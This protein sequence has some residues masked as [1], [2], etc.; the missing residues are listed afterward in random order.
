MRK[1]SL[2]LLSLILVPLAASAPGGDV[3]AQNSA[4]FSPY[5]NG[6]LAKA[7]QQG[8]SDSTIALARSST[9][10]DESAISIMRRT[11]G[12]AS[13]N[14]TSFPPF[15]G[16]DEQRAI[17]GKASGGRAKYRTLGPFLQRAQ[18]ET[19]VPPGIILAIYG[20]ESNYGSYT[21]S[22]DILNVT[23]SLAYEGRRRDLFEAEYIAALK[24]IDRG[25]PRY[26]MQGSFAGAMG[27]PQFLPSVYLRLAQ[28]GNGD[29]EA[30]IWASEAD[31][32]ASIANYLHEAGWK[33][34]EPWGVRA[35]VPANLD[36][37][38]IGNELTEIRCD[39]V[40]GRH[41]QWKTIAEWRALGVIAQ[42]PTPISDDSFAT[43][44]E[45]DGEGRGGYLL[46]GNYRAILDYNCSNFY[47]LAV[48]LLADEIE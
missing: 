8:V 22:F 26:R 25:V 1:V 40:F 48:G 43:L 16:S 35:S 41:S 23:A 20:K 18:A 36:R 6:L 42:G 47:A 31:A 27:K 33:R 15:T 11:S 4:G 46:T 17:I 29:G 21:G 30:D 28:D 24:M 2:F 3:Y 38:A 19:G 37:T 14:S 32:V 9:R 13:S 10:L 5:L 7:K 45:P 39:R 34:G 12:G 44:L